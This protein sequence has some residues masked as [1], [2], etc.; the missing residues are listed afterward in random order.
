MQTMGDCCIHP[1]LLLRGTLCLRGFCSPGVYGLYCWREWRPLELTVL[2]FS[3]SSSSSCLSYSQ[4]RW[5]LESGD[6]PTK[7]RSVQCW[8]RPPPRRARSAPAPCSKCRTNATISHLSLS[9]VPGGERDH[10]VLQTDLTE[11]QRLTSGC[12]EGDPT[13]HPIW[14]ALL[15]RRVAMAAREVGQT[16]L[17]GGDDAAR[18]TEM[19][20]SRYKWWAKASDHS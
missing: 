7:T 8:R 6:S 20:L 10:R 12:S 14:G 1:P 11:V 18:A 4:Q 5:R 15:R 9:P 3:P 13:P 16:S 17:L 19:I 2:S